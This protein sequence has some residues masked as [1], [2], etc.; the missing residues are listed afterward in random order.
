MDISFRIRKMAKIFNSWELLNKEF[1][2]DRARKIEERMVVLRA[3]AILEQVSHLPPERRH[4][5]SGK[6][7]SQFAVDLDQPARL[8]FE[9]DHDPILLNEAGGIDL[10]KVTAIR[11]LEVTEDYH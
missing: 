1:G 10:A 6:R 4:E 3:A 8:I 9:P 7:K 11:I 5:L 2:R